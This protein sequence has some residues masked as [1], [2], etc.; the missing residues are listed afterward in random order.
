MS[1]SF[2]NA[3]EYFPSLG[4]QLIDFTSAEDST[5]R[6]HS[7]R[8]AA[9]LS[10]AVLEEKK[11][12]VATFSFASP[13]DLRTFDQE[14]RGHLKLNDEVRQH[15]MTG[16]PRVFQRQRP[17]HCCLPLTLEETERAEAIYE[18]FRPNKPLEK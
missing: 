17:P 1:A 6:G 16:A 2:Q 9:L 12:F 3:L 13:S 8:A 15:W 14:I 7:V 4:A 10:H 11:W 18:R 5:V